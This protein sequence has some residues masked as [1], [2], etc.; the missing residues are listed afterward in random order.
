MLKQTLAFATLLG[1][2]TAGSLAHAGDCTSCGNEPSCG[3]T[4]SCCARPA[5]A[6]APKTLSG[7]E[8]RCIRQTSYL[9]NACGPMCLPKY[10]HCCPTCD[11]CHTA[12]PHSRHV[13]QDCCWYGNLFGL[14]PKVRHHAKK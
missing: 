10:V 7:Y 4:A 3:E 8:L 11:N 9:E 2:M 14:P 1:I 13:G 12:A 6:P 5:P